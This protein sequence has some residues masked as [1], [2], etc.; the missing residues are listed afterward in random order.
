MLVV[1]ML[2]GMFMNVVLLLLVVLINNF[3]SVEQYLLHLKWITRTS[4]KLFS[5]KFFLTRAHFFLCVRRNVFV[6]FVLWSFC[7]HTYDA[8]YG[9][10][11]AKFFIWVSLYLAIEKYLDWNHSRKT[12]VRWML[13]NPS[14]QTFV[15]S[16][17]TQSFVGDF[18]S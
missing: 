17:R 13:H 10:T 5:K 6:P 3:M 16:S 2:F 9:V 12:E 14:L 4:S 18:I 15:S 11:K 1:V 8:W 7:I